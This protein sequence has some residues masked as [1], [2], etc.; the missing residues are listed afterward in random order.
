M[1]QRRSRLPSG[2]WV[3]APSGRRRPDRLS[4][5]FDTGELEPPSSNRCVRHI[6]P[7]NVFH[8]VSMTPKQGPYCSTG[9]A[10]ATCKQTLN[11]TPKYG[12]TLILHFQGNCR[13]VN[14]ERLL[15]RDAG[16]GRRCT[17]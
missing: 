14:Q 11:A 17:H 1:L 3:H 7:T 2:R 15:L 9:Y 6:I 10:F 12:P 8:R 13:A 5:T 16:Y 4:C